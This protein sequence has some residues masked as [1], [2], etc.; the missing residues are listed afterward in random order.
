MIVKC[1]RRVTAFTD[2]EK[3]IFILVNQCDMRFILSLFVEVC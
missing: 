1:G 3:P 2:T